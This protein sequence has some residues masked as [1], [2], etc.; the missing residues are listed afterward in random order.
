MKLDTQLLAD[1]TAF[2][3]IE[4]DMLDNKEYQQW[5]DL[6]LESGLYIVPV[7]HAATDYANTLNVAYDDNEMRQLRI[8]RLTS[9]DAI[10]TQLSENTVRTMSRFRILDDI[11]GFVRVRCAYSLYENNKNG[12]RCY[13]AN[14]QFKLV[15]DGGSFKIAEKVV[16]VMKSSQHLTTVSYLF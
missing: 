10:S 2:L 4:A 7:D 12:L 11:D 1:V 13:P 3:N 9:G 5:L 14:L 8:E 6:W 15:R 16:K